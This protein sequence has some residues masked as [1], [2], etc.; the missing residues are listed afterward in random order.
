[1]RS[2]TFALIWEQW[3][4]VRATFLLG[5]AAMLFVTLLPQNV[6]LM[7]AESRTLAQLLVYLLAM[8]FLLINL[9]SLHSSRE[10][11]T[12]I[13]PRRMFTVPMRRTKIALIQFVFRLLC[14]LGGGVLFLLV[15]GLRSNSEGMTKEIPALVPIFA[16]IISIVIALGWTFGKRSTVTG[17]IATVVLTPVVVF[18]LVWLGEWL[19]ETIRVWFG[20][21]FR[22]LSAYGI[23][24]GLDQPLTSIG[25]YVMA[26]M[27]VLGCAAMCVASA[28][29]F[30]R[31]TQPLF[32]PKRPDA[33]AKFLT[34]SRRHSGFS[35]FLFEFRH[36]GIWYP[37]FCFALASVFA[38]MSW[39]GHA[40]TWQELARLLS[41]MVWLPLAAGYL[42]GLFLIMYDTRHFTQDLSLRTR[43]LTTSSLA[44]ARA[45][46]SLCSIGLAVAVYALLYAAVLVAARL[47][48]P[49]YVVAQ[50]ANLNWS[51]WLELCSLLPIV[52]LAA[53]VLMWTPLTWTLYV[54]CMGVA[55]I[56]AE[57]FAPSHWVLNQ[58]LYRRIAGGLLI[59][60]YTANCIRIARQLRQRRILTRGILFAAAALVFVTGGAVLLSWMAH[61]PVFAELKANP[62]TLLGIAGLSTF[63][64]YALLSQALW[65]DRIR[66]GESPLGIPDVLSIRTAKAV[67]HA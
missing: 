51:D 60:A 28:N 52:A 63:P 44:L 21:G 11:A 65:L 12:V 9:F 8:I 42:T 34:P 6:I 45:G 3:R 64:A 30:Y 23:E 49:S 57:A 40:N 55:V 7:D 4:Q 53:F 27:C 25:F 32:V 46:M 48:M 43:P 14:F 17:V 58:E 67:N 1:M 33:F 15:T 31:N 18:L 39:F 38:M 61:S 35:A 16:C 59:I 56:S 24:L 37:L 62:D 13:L 47:D 29:R 41:E 22:R 26:T 5:F 10:Q 54:F 36:K 19:H 20:L 2:P 50:Y 66:H